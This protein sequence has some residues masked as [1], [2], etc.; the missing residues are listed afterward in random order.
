MSEKVSV[1]IEGVNELLGGGIIKGKSF[2]VSGNCGTGKTL[3]AS[4]FIQEAVKKKQAAVYVS[5]EQNKDMLMKDL[6]RVGI[7]WKDNKHIS[8]IGGNLAY[9][10]K[11]KEE[12]GAKILDVIEE[13]KEVVEETGAKKVAIDSINLFLSLF[14]NPQEQR[15]G[16]AT[17]LYELQ[18][19]NC[20]VLLTCETKSKEALSWHGFEEFVVDGVLLLKRDLDKELNDSKRYFRIVKMRGTGFKE[21]DYPLKIDKDG[22]HVYMNDPSKGFF[23]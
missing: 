10:F 4:H 17:L 23:T 8:I 2:L 16:L 1:G 13:I 6:E 22:L 11:L 21:G 12:R 3:F 19:L 20:T 5:L 7:T 15:N 18:E 14:E 9:I